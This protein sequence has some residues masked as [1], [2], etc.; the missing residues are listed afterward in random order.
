[1]KTSFMKTI[2][3]SDNYDWTIGKMK[4]E[5]RFVAHFFKTLIRITGKWSFADTLEN[6]RITSK[7]FFNTFILNIFTSKYLIVKN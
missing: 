5:F 1:M 6:K 3:T 4:G 7:N 2:I